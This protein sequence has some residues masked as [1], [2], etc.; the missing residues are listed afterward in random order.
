MPLFAEQL[1]QNPTK[2]QPLLVIYLLIIH[3]AINISELSC[4]CQAILSLALVWWTIQVFSIKRRISFL[5]RFSQLTSKYFD[6]LKI[7]KT[8]KLQIPPAC[9][10]LYFDKYGYYD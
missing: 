5:P 2:N 6:F 10:N 7:A 9:M 4:P 3:Q 1:Q 8:L